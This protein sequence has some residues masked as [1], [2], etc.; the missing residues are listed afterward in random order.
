[1]YACRSSKSLWFGRTEEVWKLG[2][3]AWR[4]HPGEGLADLSLLALIVCP[5]GPI[6]QET[7]NRRIP[8]NRSDLLPQ[9]QRNGESGR[10]RV[11]RREKCCAYCNGIA[12]ECVTNGTLSEN[13][14]S[15]CLW[16]VKL[17]QEGF[18][19]TVNLSMWLQ[20]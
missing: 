13:T 4:L 6:A 14:A 12:N 18:I 11:G 15:M 20:V 1:M 10:G 2:V 16:R 5:D 17:L 7:G 9:S 8:S 3:L 19:N